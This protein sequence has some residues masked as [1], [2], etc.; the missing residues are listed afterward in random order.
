MGASDKLRYNAG[1]MGLYRLGGADV[2]GGTLWVAVVL[3]G[4]VIGCAAGAAPAD[5]GLAL[6]FVGTEAGA[7]DWNA[8]LGSE[9][10]STPGA[11]AG[12]LMLDWPSLVEVLPGVGSGSGSSD[13][14][15]EL[16]F[17]MCLDHARV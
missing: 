15:V 5:G 17:P 3:A 9:G 7:C 2:L 6:T 13:W 14:W 11:A 1:L 4:A 8:G 12:K 10:K 16:V